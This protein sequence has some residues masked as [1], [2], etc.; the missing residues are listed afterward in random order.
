MQVLHL[1][2]KNIGSFGDKLQVIDYPANGNLV[3][4]K[5]VSGVGK[6]TYL[7]IT[8]LLLFGKADGIAKNSIANRVN[9]NGYIKG[10][11]KEGEQTYIIE[12]G[13]QP[14]YLNIFK[15]DGTNLDMIGIKD[16]QT[17][18]NNEIVKMSYTLFSNIISLSLINFKSFLKMSPFDR[19][20]IIDRVFSLEIINHIFELIKKDIK[21]ISSNI[22][23]DNSNIFSLTSTIEQSK[24]ELEN[25]KETN[26]SSIGQK[27]KTNLSIIEEYNQK[28]IKISEKYN[29]INNLLVSYNN[30]TSVLN[31]ELIKKKT[32]I[33]E[34]DK[35]L[36][37]FEQER[38]PT[39]G[40]SLHT[41]EFENIKEDLVQQ[42]KSA[43]DYIVRIQEK[44]REIE[45]A[46][47]PYIEA[48]NT[49][50]KAN[51]EIGQSIMKLN[52]DNSSMQSLIKNSSEF[53]S[54]Q[55]IINKTQ[56]NI[57]ATKQR[58]ND[59]TKKM[60][61]LEILQSL[62]SMDGVKKQ[63]IENYLPRLNAEIK[64]TLIRL[65]FPYTLTF[66]NTFDSHL[67]D[68]GNEINTETL[69]MGEHKRVDLA[70]LCSIFKLIKRKYPNL[71]IFT[72]DEVLSSI[73]PTNSAEILRF[74]KEFSEEMKVNIYVISHVS[75]SEDLFDDCIEIYKDMRFSDIKHYNQTIN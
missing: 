46:K 11:V 44:F 9:K 26:D 29:E 47:K 64:E 4:I 71:N 35:K 37:L 1:E 33:K 40:S 55:N 38:C 24:K 41:S 63:V 70:V 10:I 57:N 17:Y 16:A 3:M 52:A 62:F 30:M 45:I 12:R 65:N 6:S 67:T 58:I 53:Q 8:K 18:I 39:C 36:K 43:N 13:F 59:N 69:S 23:I 48:N 22:N 5:G 15:E 2:F 74:L 19:R 68:L 31:N 50:S 49:L 34:I 51:I 73:D 66:D 54:I 72:L 60:N 75:M 20:E 25:I 42:K 21:E 7:N 32:E 28:L 56:D 61:N 27:I 14:T